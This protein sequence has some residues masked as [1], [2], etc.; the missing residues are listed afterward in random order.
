MG[1]FRTVD[2]FIVNADDHLSQDRWAVYHRKLVALVSRAA[3]GIHFEWVS[4]SNARVQS[5]C[6]RFE[7]SDDDVGELKHDLTS[8]AGEYGDGADSW[9]IGWDDVKPKL[10]IPRKA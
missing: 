10:L 6:V 1:E 3:M 8:L 4:S 5:A 2:A 9:S 7:I